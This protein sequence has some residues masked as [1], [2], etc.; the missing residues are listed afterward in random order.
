MSWKRI[1]TKRAAT[2]E[3]TLFTSLHPDEEEA[4]REVVERFGRFVDL[5]VTLVVNDV[6]R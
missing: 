3:A 6:S 5:P 1:S 2:V 4:L